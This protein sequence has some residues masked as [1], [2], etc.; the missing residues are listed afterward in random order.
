MSTGPAV[1]Q[2]V[3]ADA[4]FD[5]MDWHD[6]AVHAAALEPAPP[7]PGRSAAGPGLHHR[8]SSSRTARDHAQRLDLPGHALSSARRGILT[9]T[10]TCTE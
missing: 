1:A 10:S 2:T 6:N 8:G 5:A 3:C 9:P 4:D 7:H